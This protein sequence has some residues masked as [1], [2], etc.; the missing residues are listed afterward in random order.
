MTFDARQIARQVALRFAQ[1]AEEFVIEDPA[2][3]PA[4]RIER[5]VPEHHDLHPQ[6]GKRPQPEVPMAKDKLARS[7][8][9]ME[10]LRRLKQM[11][12]E[13]AAAILQYEEARRG[14][15]EAMLQ[16]AGVDPRLWDDVKEILKGDWDYYERLAFVQHANNDAAL[17]FIE[18]R[19]A[20]PFEGALRA[21]ENI[22]KRAVR[23][24]LKRKPRTSGSGSTRVVRAEI[25]PWAF[26]RR[27]AG[28]LAE[29]IQRNVSGGRDIVYSTLE[30]AAEKAMKA[31]KINLEVR[32]NTAQ[33]E[34]SWQV[35]VSGPAGDKIKG[36][37]EH[38]WSKVNNNHWL[39]NHRIGT[40][41]PRRVYF[42][43]VQYA[44]NF[45]S[46]LGGIRQWGGRDAHWSRIGH[47]V[48]QFLAHEVSKD[49][50]LRPRV[51][52]MLEDSLV[53][54]A[55]ENPALQE[56]VLRLLGKGKRA[57]DLQRLRKMYELDPTDP[58]VN[59]LLKRLW[60]R[61]G[62]PIPLGKGIENGRIRVHHYRGW[63]HVYDLTNAGKR[64]KNVD[65]FV[66]GVQFGVN[67]VQP[68]LDAFTSTLHTADYQTARKNAQDLLKLHPRMEFDE[69]QKKGVRVDKPGQDPV[70]VKGPKIYVKAEPQDFII[71]DL[72]DPINM[73][74]AMTPMRGKKTHAKKFY[75]W[76]KQN[77]SSIHRMT[78]REILKSL[79]AAG[80]KYH[81]YMGMD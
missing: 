65:Y 26:M 39:Q 5:E 54:L 76:A 42:L 52:K 32:F 55:H 19:N 43:A 63:I 47:H 78:F 11:G 81:Q 29:Y 36:Y 79:D 56:D 49:V 67:D 72:G 33:P 51:A 9:E 30:Q 62:R 37:L 53:R 70:E 58:G 73:P 38:E 4:Q 22:A 75:A 20:V 74:R 77:E 31:T 14:S 44:N 8:D 50:G 27:N 25:N 28:D 61:M 80:I 12:D 69:R 41:N 6:P 45:G 17:Y 10:R 35:N 7:R 15:L 34:L 1:E 21:F 66:V 59:N 13:G 64:G 60:G 23:E 48:W 3:H 2:A 40:D 18:E 46:V 16:R 24:R 57:T 71:H 68:L